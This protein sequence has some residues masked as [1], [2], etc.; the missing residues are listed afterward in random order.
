MNIQNV[1]VFE[2][3]THEFYHQKTIVKSNLTVVTRQ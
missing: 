1:Y 3:K 2:H